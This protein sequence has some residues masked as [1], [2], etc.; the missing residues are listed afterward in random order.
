MEPEQRTFW[1]EV[2]GH[3]H[4]RLRQ[5]AILG[6]VLLVAI[7]SDWFFRHQQ[8][9]E[10]QFRLTPQLEKLI[11]DGFTMADQS[12]SAKEV[13][14]ALN[15]PKCLVASTAPAQSIRIECIPSLSKEVSSAGTSDSKWKIYGQE[16]P[17][18][19]YRCV[20]LFAP[21]ALLFGTVATGSQ[22]RKLHSLLRSEISNVSV[23]QKL[24]SPYFARVTT[25]YGEGQ[26]S[27]ILIAAVINLVHVLAAFAYVPA[28]LI[29]SNV[30]E[31]VVS[32]GKIVSA[33]IATTGEGTPNALI[34]TWVAVFFSALA[35]WI[36]VVSIF[37]RLVITHSP[38]CEE[39]KGAA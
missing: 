30:V 37:A 21:I 2:L 19:L 12:K 35:L 9:A 34:L 6:L 4:T 26:R 23:Q 10:E 36:A 24:N 32:D 8:L 28:V 7:A 22:L 3:L 1:V 25:T 18:V 14:Q 13:Q 16:L 5:L 17:K 27:Q 29:L 15:T 31:V 39:S 11:F 38:K 20:V 33:S